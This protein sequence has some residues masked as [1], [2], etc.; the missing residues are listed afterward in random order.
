MGLGTAAA[1]TRLRRRPRRHGYEG[2]ATINFLTRIVIKLE[3]IR[4]IYCLEAH[5]TMPPSLRAF[6]VFDLI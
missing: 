1:K 3:K 6:K 4:N 2:A 5:G